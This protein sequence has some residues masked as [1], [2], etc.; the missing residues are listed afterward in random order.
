MFCGTKA[1]S[2]SGA[3]MGADEEERTITAVQEEDAAFRAGVQR[4][5]SDL[6]E[7]KDARIERLQKEW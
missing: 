2:E 5:V 6:W 3:L 4:W 1:A 7:Q